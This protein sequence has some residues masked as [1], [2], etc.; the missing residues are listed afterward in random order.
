MIIP[1]RVDRHLGGEALHVVVEEVVGELAAVL[2]E[3]LGHLG[4][5]GRDD[6]APDPAVRERHARLHRSVGVDAVAAVDEEVGPA[7]GHGLEDRHAADV[8]VDAPALARDV[9][10]PH[11]PHV[12][13]AERSGGEAARDGFAAGAAVQVLCRD[14][15]V[16][17]AAWQQARHP[18]L[19]GSAGLRGEQRAADATGEAELGVVGHLD[20]HPRGTVGARPHDA[21]VPG[22][23]AGLHAVGEDR[24]VGLRE[25]DAR[26]HQRRG[27]AECACLEQRATVEGHARFLVAGS[28]QFETRGEL[29]Q[30]LSVQPLT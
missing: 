4:L 23:V 29:Q 19:P 26:G 21:A 8:G 2:V 14:A 16:G 7:V 24:A 1:L 27:R 6:V 5:L 3:R 30:R 11:E 13:A 18:D 22:D 20:E 25:A 9:T 17:G 15:V 28:G 10:G 12:V